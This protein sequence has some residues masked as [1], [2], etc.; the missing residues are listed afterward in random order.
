LIPIFWSDIRIAFARKMDN[1]VLFF[2][3]HDPMKM[4]E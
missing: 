1:Q 4:D 2:N 3:K